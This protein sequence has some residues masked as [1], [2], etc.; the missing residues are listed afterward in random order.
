MPRVF[1]PAPARDLTGGL[2]ELDVEAVSVRRLIESL[3][4]RFPGFRD[5]VLE[6]GGLKPG[7]RIAIDGHISAM[8]LLARLEPES[9][10]HFL[11]AVGG[12]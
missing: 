4:T 5:R 9:E 10:V 1:I 2:V 8:G 12:G 7:L 6:E 3:E 11:T